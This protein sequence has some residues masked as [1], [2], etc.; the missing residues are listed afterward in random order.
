MENL[1]QYQ[2]G[3][4]I[5]IQLHYYSMERKKCKCKTKGVTEKKGLTKQLAYAILG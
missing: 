2:N 1:E 3:I 4:I 5:E